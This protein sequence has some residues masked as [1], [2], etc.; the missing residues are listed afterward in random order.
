MQ[1]SKRTREDVHTR[2][3]EMRSKV[4]WKETTLQR[5]MNEFKEC[6]WYRSLHD[7]KK[8]KEKL[9]EVRQECIRVY[10]KDIWLV[11]VVYD[12]LREKVKEFRI[13]AM[14]RNMDRCFELLEQHVQ[15]NVTVQVNDEEISIKQFDRGNYG[16]PYS[17][18]LCSGWQLDDGVRY[19][20]FVVNRGRG[21]SP[22]Y[23]APD[24]T[25]K[26]MGSPRYPDCATIEQVTLPRYL[27]LCMDNSRVHRKDTLFQCVFETLESHIKT[28]QHNLETIDDHL[29]EQMVTDLHDFVL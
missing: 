26:E 24:A 22:E 10:A 9:D 29:F 5:L 12:V 2:L 18:K 28:L 16:T 6:I 11:P 8:A 25:H 17:T 27:Y 13:E 21:W 23:Y 19:D 7:W 20:V 3:E 14:M 1:T 4:M 15:N